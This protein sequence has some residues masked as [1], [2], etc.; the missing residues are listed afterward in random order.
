M[1]RWNP[2]L[3]TDFSFDEP[4]ALSRASVLDH[5]A[6]RVLGSA[7]GHYRAR[8]V[9][10]Q[11]QYFDCDLRFAEPLHIQKVLPAGLCIVQV[12]EGHW[13]HRIDGA[14]NRYTPGM[15]SVL[16]LAESMETVDRLPAGSHAR[17]AGLRIA[18]HYLQELVEQDPQLEP[19]LGLLDDGMR[20]TALRH[21]RVLGGLLERLYHSP[22]HGVLE[23]LHQESLSLAVLVELAAH[24]RG[25]A[26]VAQ[27][28]VRGQRDLAQEARRLL[29]ADLA[30][31]PGSQA[32]ARQLG[33][34][35][36]TLRR[37]FNQVFGQSML[38]YIRQQRM[39][40]A[41][42]LLR[43]QKWQAAQIAYRLGYAN[44]AN[45]SNAYKRHFGHPPGA[46]R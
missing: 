45:F 3:D 33:V 16:G 37:A 12:L 8:S 14:L 11:V 20:L 25:H 44:P 23:R 34:G 6:G 35:E 28:P 13:Q 21:C 42:D 36:S 19:L 2:Y 41:R 38:Q 18:A 43:Q 7:T 46:E 22:Y 4:Q 29:D 39:E 30:Q 40:V 32:L 24:L 9:R 26:K 1:E 10:H 31:P 15:P 5:A 17:M 27:V